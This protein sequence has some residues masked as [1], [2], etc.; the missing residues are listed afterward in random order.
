V[1]FSLGVRDIVFKNTSFVFIAKL[2]ILLFL[3]DERKK[4]DKRR[5]GAANEVGYQ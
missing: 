4:T 5:S 3:C 1:I 2:V